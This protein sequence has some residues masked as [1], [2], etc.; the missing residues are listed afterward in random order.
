[1]TKPWKCT[2]C[3]R[4]FASVDD[5]YSHCKKKHNRVGMNAE[6]K[7]TRAEKQGEYE[8][9]ASRAV[10]AQLDHAMGIDNPDYDWLVEPY[11]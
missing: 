4:A 2:K 8:T 10:Q 5:L 3:E 11:Q 9:I 1:M 7:A 6:A